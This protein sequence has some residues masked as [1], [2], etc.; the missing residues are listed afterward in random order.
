MD[1]I[2]LIDVQCVGAPETREA[3]FGG[4]KTGFQPDGE[5]GGLSGL[6]RLSS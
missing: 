6:R 5:S 1:E 2:R 4:A 3:Y